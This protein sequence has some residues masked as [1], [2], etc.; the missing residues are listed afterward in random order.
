M[1]TYIARKTGETA[2]TVQL[3]VINDETT[4]TLKEGDEFVTIATNIG[5]FGEDVHE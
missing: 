2:S 1:Y 3:E 4:I 5:L